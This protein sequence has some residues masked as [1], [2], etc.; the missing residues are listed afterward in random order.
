MDCGEIG[1]GVG[2]GTG[3]GEG[4]GVKVGVAVGRSVGV[5]LGVGVMAALGV[6][7]GVAVA[8]RGSGV[9]AVASALGLLVTVLGVRVVGCLVS[10]TITAELRGCSWP[11]ADPAAGNHIVT[12][13]AVSTAARNTDHQKASSVPILPF[14]WFPLLRLHPR[15]NIR[16]RKE[17]G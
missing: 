8:V 4:V 10:A 5:G 7:V 9:V 15:R 2:V 14:T 1:V 16:L 6:G 17:P 11:E 12:E 3:V 13:M